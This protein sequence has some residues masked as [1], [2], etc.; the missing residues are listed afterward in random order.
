[1]AEKPL[2]VT[3]TIAHLDEADRRRDDEFAPPRLLVARRERTLTQKIEFV[4]V[5]AALEPEQQAVVALP[6]RVD[7]FLID[8]QRIDDAAHLDEL[9]PVAAV[10]GETRDL[11]GRHGPDLSEA[12]LG[13]HAFEAGARRPARRRAAEIFV[14]H[15]NLRPAE[16]QEAIAHGVLKQL[17]LGNVTKAEIRAN[18]SDFKFHV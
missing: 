10:A 13:D 8:Q 18:P 3:A 12:N 7:R 9:L 6:G 11:A 1:M 2:S 16:D 15:L 17:A 4:F 5:E 14:H